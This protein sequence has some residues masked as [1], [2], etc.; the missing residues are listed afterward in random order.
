MQRILLT[1]TLLTASIQI[2][3][4]E[5]GQTLHDSQCIECHSRMTGGDGT[6]IYGRDDR[7]ATTLEKLQQR[8]SHC[9]KGANTGW[10]ETEIHAVTEYL[11][12]TFYHY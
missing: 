10:T 7:L 4:A 1:L 3:L 11:N 12:S 5:Q 2:T 8:V 9:S 6:V